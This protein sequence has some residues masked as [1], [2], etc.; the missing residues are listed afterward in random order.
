MARLTRGSARVQGD[1]VPA[2]NAVERFFQSFR[3]PN[4]DVEPPS[5]Q[6]DLSMLTDDEKR[7]RITR[8]DR[9]ERKVGLVASVIALLLA[10]YA[11]VPAMVEKTVVSHPTAKPKGHV[12]KAGLT[13]VAS[14]NTCNGAYP[15]GHYTFPLVV[16]VVLAIA[17][18]V[19]VRIGRRAPLAFALLMTG[20]AFGELPVLVPFVAAGGWV[21]LRAW[22]TQKYGAPSA[23]TG[24]SGWSPP[25][26]RGTVK[27]ERATR[28]GTRSGAG[29]K[30]SATGKKRPGA[31]KR[32]TPK[33]PPRKRAKTLET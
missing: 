23:K 25:P 16:T 18:Y 21:M 19:T 17:I 14:T 20:L 28:G 5:E 22:R 3:P 13:F 4:A 11:N 33:S 10:I 31:N 27:R 29:T 7:A 8:I 2:P 15:A 6:V 24:V 32:Y 1:G 30:P 26:P 9:N 12:C